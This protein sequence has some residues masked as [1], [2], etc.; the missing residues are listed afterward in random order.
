[1]KFITNIN[2]MLVDRFG[3]LGPLIAVGGLGLLLVLIALPTVLRKQKDPFRKLKDTGGTATGDG[4]QGLRV[5]GRNEKLDRFAAY[6]E[7]QDEQELSATQLKMIKAGY[8][9]KGAIQMFNFAKLALG[10][11][12]LILGTL[13]V[14]IS[15]G[16]GYYAPQGVGATAIATLNVDG[17]EEI[18]TETEEYCEDQIA[19][20]T[21]MRPVQAVCIDDKG[22]PHPASQVD[23]SDRVPAGYKGE[24]FRCMAGTSMQ[25]TLGSV[26][27]GKATFA[28]GETFA[29]R[30]GEALVHHANG[31]LT[32]APQS[33]QRSC[34]E[35][36]L[37]RRHGAGIKLV[38]SKLSTKTCIPRTREVTRTVQGEGSSQPMI[39]DG[40][41]GQGVY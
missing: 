28:N 37:L 8:R 9:S 31:Q 39:F 35:R 19:I 33:P 25:V 38:Q 26:Q 21:V 40:G 7:P 4:E 6:L 24:L 27:N 15:G 5:G 11:G 36:S 32:C 29:C 3:E 34:N 1:M 20:K 16:G 17:G 41:V 2:E 22:V 12:G 30:K 18:I 10:I 14:L 23:A 13:Y